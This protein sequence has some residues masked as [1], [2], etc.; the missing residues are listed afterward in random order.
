MLGYEDPGFRDFVT[1]LERPDVMERG[2]GIYQV[3]TCLSPS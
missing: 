2:M 3:C 1:S